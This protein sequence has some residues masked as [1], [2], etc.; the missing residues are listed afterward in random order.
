MNNQAITTLLSTIR[1]MP[2]NDS[3]ALAILQS[4]AEAIALEKMAS[5]KDIPEAIEKKPLKCTAVPASSN[6]H[7]RN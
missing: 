2:D 3:A 7:R 6:L 4:V 5:F 1:N